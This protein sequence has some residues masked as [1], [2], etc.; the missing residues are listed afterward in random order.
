[1]IGTYMLSKYYM[2]FDGTPPESGQSYLRIGFG[3]ADFDG[4]G[5]P[6][7]KDPEDNILLWVALLL[8][9]FGLLIVACCVFRKC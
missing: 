8:G 3:N 5:S 4:G 2:V 9:L 1:M 6:G 7:D